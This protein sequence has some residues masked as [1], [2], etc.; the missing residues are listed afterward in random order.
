MT[1][2]ATDLDLGDNA[3]LRY[4]IGDVTARCATP[5]CTDDVVKLHVDARNGELRAETV[6]DRE[7]HSQIDVIVLAIDHGIQPQTGSTIYAWR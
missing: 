1:A 6:L 4:V 2:T 7:T 3:R 5:G